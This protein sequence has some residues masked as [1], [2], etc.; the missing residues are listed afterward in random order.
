MLN[1]ADWQKQL[2]EILFPLDYVQVHLFFN[3]S[4]EWVLSLI[5]FFKLIDSVFMRTLQ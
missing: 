4:M 2:G 5:N 3:I 1:E